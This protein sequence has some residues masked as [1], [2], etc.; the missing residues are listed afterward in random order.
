[1]KVNG[2][3]IERTSLTIC[4]AA[5]ASARAFGERKECRASLHLHK[6]PASVQWSQRKRQHITLCPGL[7][8]FLQLML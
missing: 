4:F 8:K 6:A 1:M 2:G 3:S 5:D 7:Y